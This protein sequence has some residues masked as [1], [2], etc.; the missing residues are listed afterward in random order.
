MNTDDHS[1]PLTNQ[2]RDTTAELGRRTA[3]VAK[4]VSDAASEAAQ[5][6][7]SRVGEAVDRTKEFTQH[8]V[9][10]TVNAAHRGTDKVKNIYQSASAKAED[11]L[12]NSKKY[13]HQHPF[14]VVLGT[15]IGGLALGYLIG[16]A[17]RE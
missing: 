13:V 2:L 17:R 8:A 15:L 1:S 9:D 6:L 14:P 3:A 5:T 10:S 4:G 16:A 7:T 11:V 12:A